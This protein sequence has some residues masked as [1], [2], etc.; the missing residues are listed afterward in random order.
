M[1]LSD[2]AKG[3]IKE[4]R[5]QANNTRHKSDE[6]SIKALRQKDLSKFHDTFAAMQSAFSGLDARAQEQTEMARRAAELA[7][8]DEDERNAILKS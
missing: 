6:Y 3:I 2:D 8:L 1:S 4:I 5:E 7:E